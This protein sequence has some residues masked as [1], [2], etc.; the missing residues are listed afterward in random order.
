MKFDASVFVQVYHG[1]PGI[2]DACS[3]PDVDVS[4]P[5]PLLNVLKLDD[6]V[7]SVTSYVC[8]DCAAVSADSDTNLAATQMARHV[9]K[10][11]P[12]SPNY[13]GCFV[14]LMM[15]QRVEGDPDSISGTVTYRQAIYDAM[16]SRGRREVFVCMLCRSVFCRSNTSAL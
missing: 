12:E 2:L 5:L 14:K 7:S 10:E 9:V 11:H 16:H 1:V 6:N 3:H 4:A 13:N 15:L 8:F